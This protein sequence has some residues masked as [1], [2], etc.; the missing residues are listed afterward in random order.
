MKPHLQDSGNFSHLYKAQVLRGHTCYFLVLG[1]LLFIFPQLLFAQ[2]T[3][4][5][6]TPIRASG[7]GENV[8]I[9]HTKADHQGNLLVLASREANG[10]AEK[11]QLQKLNAAGNVLW[12]ATLQSGLEE[13]PRVLALDAA[14]NA[15][16]LIQ[17]RE[18]D[19]DVGGTLAKFSS[20]GDLLWAAAREGATADM[21]SMA[22]LLLTEN[23]IYVAGNGGDN[24]NP[25]ILLRKLDLAGQVMW[26]Q[27]YNG[28]FGVKLAADG[29]QR[30]VLAGSKDVY[31][32]SSAELS[33]VLLLSYEAST[34]SLHFDRNYNY[35]FKNGSSV[36]NG[37]D[38]PADLHI[39][40]AGEI[41]VVSNSSPYPYVYD[42]V[43]MKTDRQGNKLWQTGIGKKWP[44]GGVDESMALYRDA[45]FA[46]DG[47]VV[48]LTMEALYRR[49]PNY[50]MVRVSGEGKRLWS[51]TFNT[52][53]GDTVMMPNVNDTVA[54]VQ[55][56][57]LALD[58]AGNIAVIAEAGR[59]VLGHTSFLGWVY[60]E[61]T[62]PVTR[63][64]APDG[65]LLWEQQVAG[66][67]DLL[68]DVSG[69]LYITG[70]MGGKGDR[71][72][73]VW[74]YKT[75]EACHIPVRV[76]LSLPPF[77]MKA[78][79]QVRTTADFGTYIALTEA[80]VRWSWGDN[81][82]S[83]SY[84]LPDNPRI[85]G[86]HRYTAAGIYTIGL[87]VS[88]SCLQPVSDDYRQEMVI[89]DPAAGNVSGAGLLRVPAESPAM[90]TSAFAFAAR[91]TTN[92]AFAKPSGAALF[93]LNSSHILFSK[94]LDWLV[95]KDNR[96]ALQGIGTVN[97][98]GRFKF[99]A[100][101]EDGGGA[102]LNDAA[103]QLRL[104]VWD[105]NAYGKLVYDNS[106]AS[107]RLSLVQQL[108]GIGG[109]QVLI[110][111]KQ[112]DPLFAQYLQQALEGNGPLPELVAYP[113]PFSDKTTINFALEHGGSYAIDLYDMK[114]TRIRQLQKG[115]AAAKTNVIV[116]VDGATL[117]QGIYLARLQTDTGMKTVKL[118][119]NK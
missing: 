40:P 104:Q 55:P 64:Y 80:G 38:T 8:K 111:H 78:G 39:S 28:G 25:K 68:F 48:V 93:V 23:D 42:V 83:I 97:G 56:E 96:A 36:H 113:N 27:V 49:P 62:V 12:Q 110:N 107:Q 1:M 94:S 50:G 89:F 99:V 15:Y 116:D 112:P 32:P 21:N 63:L 30:I 37:Y 67:N 18:N 59:K 33:N 17:L 103:D 10:A 54:V 73:F 65:S 87:D 84:T 45:A 58:K 43:L 100:T 79:E 75:A 24:R 26:E 60:E 16:V 88:Q 77:A 51:K 22:D 13:K 66:G 119:L 53:T 46:P 76:K 82:T 31:L 7:A 14:G 98:K 81:S 91:Y 57:A 69:N 106:A 86:Q 70:A 52:V 41:L 114:G 95:I 29:T 92:D 34:G 4:Q 74:K 117:A 20:D 47:S 102:G 61:P 5:W 101:M 85:T 118:L 2:L 6:K 44:L 19:T 35:L 11:M 115:T 9:I 108:P 71:Q 90:G 109:G 3:E 72:A 105:L